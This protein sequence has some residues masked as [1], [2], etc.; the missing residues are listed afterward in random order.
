MKSSR[1]SEDGLI[2]R[3]FAPL[4]GEGA[5]G[6]R[7]DA[8]TLLPPPGAELVLTCDSVVEGVHFLP[9]DPPD[10]VAA[11]ALGVNL[12]DLAAKGA[13]PLG[14]LLALAL[15]ADWT[16]DWLSRFAEGLGVSSRAAKCPLLGGDTV[17]AAGPLSLTITAIGHVPAGR[18]CG[19]RRRGP[20]ILF[21]CRGR[22]ATRC[23]GCCS[24]LGR[25]HAGPARSSRRRATISSNAINAQGPASP[26]R[27]LSAITRAPLWT[28]RTGS[29]ATLPR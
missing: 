16:E 20:A 7:D 5:L 28:S 19:V 3:F 27:A 12:S 21:V 8:A 2:E 29:Q 11:K 6:L 4:A 25:N 26:W 9:A 1:L 24:F 13:E 18:T 23:S 22:L 14:F 17:R 10:T 15:P